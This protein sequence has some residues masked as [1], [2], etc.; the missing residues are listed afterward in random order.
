MSIDFLERNQF[1]SEFKRCCKDYDQLKMATAWCG[2][3][4]HETP[5]HFIGERLNLG[6]EI[7][8]GI[9]FTHTDPETL[10][11]FWGLEHVDIRIVNNND[12]LFHPK[13]YY[14][15]RDGEFAVFIGS[16]NL[17]Y[18]GFK[19]N[20]EA[21]ILLEGSYEDQ[22]T[23]V[24]SI[25]EKLNTW[26]SN[27]LLLT[28]ER[29]DDYRAKYEKQREKED[30]YEIESAAL[31]EELTVSEKWLIKASWEEF[32]SKIR[33]ELQN[34]KHDYF[35]VIETAHDRLLPLSEKTFFAEENRDIV[36][37]LKEYGPLG[38]HRA[39]RDFKKLQRSNDSGER[40]KTIKNL[41]KIINVSEPLSYQEL[42]EDL[43]QL[44]EDVGLKMSSWSRLMAL[45]RPDIFISVSSG[46]V[47]AKLAELTEIKKSKI[48]LP[49]G[50][51][52]VLKHVHKSNWYKSDKPIEHKQQ[53][54]W[55]YRAALLDA[56][57]YPWH[58]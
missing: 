6:T 30:Q 31:D 48:N 45:F 18:H 29:L 36:L 47:R 44:I 20:T 51:I 15:K 12:P 38:M 2:V 22:S 34:I 25:E 23:F 17:T 27:A 54:Y 8:T 5:Y 46:D 39:N 52:Q 37:G 19:L 43:E 56:I 4:K 58:E 21:N 55:K 35:Y 1:H 42:E 14:F 40:K 24:K 28:K 10:E 33:K 3:Y 9:S 13:L 53:K 16:S 50:Y 41:E 32:Y 26:H 49:E 7:T 11:Y 57:L